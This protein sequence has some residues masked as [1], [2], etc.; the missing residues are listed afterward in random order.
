M[1][2]CGFIYLFL[3]TAQDKAIDLVFSSNVTESFLW[4]QLY[5][6]RKN[7]L[8]KPNIIPASHRAQGLEGIALN[9]LIYQN[10]HHLKS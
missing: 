6:R 1:L 2:L 4:V 5:C 10:I 8:N 9:K 3:N 7:I